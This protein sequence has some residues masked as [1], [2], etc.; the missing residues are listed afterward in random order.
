MKHTEALSPIKIAKGQIE[1][2]INMINDDRYCIDIS[3]QIEAVVALLRKT[4]RTILKDHLDHCVKEAIIAKDASEKI[5]EIKLLL[6]KV[7]KWE[8]K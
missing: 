2:V 4:Q 6:D 8:N 5:E 3:N 7:I 1:S